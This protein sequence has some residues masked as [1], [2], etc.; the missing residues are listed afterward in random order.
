MPSSLEAK[1]T[2]RVPVMF[3]PLVSTGSVIER[4]TEAIAA[5]WKTHPAP[6]A[7]FFT[8]ARSLTSPSITST[9]PGRRAVFSL[10]PVSK[11][12]STITS[13]PRFASSS[14]IWLPIKP[15]PPVTRTFIS[16]S[17]PSY[18]VSRTSCVSRRT[19]YVL[20]RAHES[21]K[22]MTYDIRRY[23]RKTLDA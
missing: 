14:A 1:R 6:R 15:A 9:L 20:R 10:F 12:S 2:L 8:A 13:K 18:V 23:L 19:S 11:L 3:T 5:K 4:W 17:L 16:N 21:F 22:R 7:A